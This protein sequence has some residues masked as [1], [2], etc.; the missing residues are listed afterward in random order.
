[1][2]FNEWRHR[3]TNYDSRLNAA[4]SPEQQRAVIEQIALQAMQ[5][6]VQKQDKL[7]A[8]SVMSWARAKHIVN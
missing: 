4:R 2:T 8:A 7:F 6:A 5:I 3:H 1:M